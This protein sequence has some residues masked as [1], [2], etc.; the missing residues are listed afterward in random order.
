MLEVRYN[1]LAARRFGRSGNVDPPGA[2]V[3][4]GPCDGNPVVLVHGF[5]AFAASNWF[6]LSPLLVNN[7]R[8]VF[9]LDYGDYGHGVLTKRV[10]GTGDAHRCAEELATYVDKVLAA[11]GA[12]K[13]D[14]VAHSFGGLVVQ[15]YLKRLG[16]DEHVDQVV[17]LA[18]TFHG[19]TF[20]GLLR[21]PLFCRLGARAFGDNITQQA[22]GSPFV[23]ELYSDGDTAPGI[24]YT[25]ISPMWDTFTTP[26]RAQRLAGERVTNLRHRG[27]AEHITLA[28]SR[29]A[30]AQVVQAL[31]PRR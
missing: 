13:V 5:G 25:V 6:A 30:L 14:L 9:A 23:R 15:Y 22:A 8:R 19:T 4:D 11:T 17:G 31:A 3:W 7:G 2:N 29:R 28:F 27:P 26:I 1:A 10:K 21:V 12:A 24:T 20:N 16:G 18:P